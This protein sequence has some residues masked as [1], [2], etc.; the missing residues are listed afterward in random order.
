M[1]ARELQEEEPDSKR[2]VAFDPS[3]QA[4]GGGRVFRN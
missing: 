4:S 1:S 2:H 3:S